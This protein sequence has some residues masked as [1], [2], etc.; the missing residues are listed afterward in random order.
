[1]TL[2]AC[3]F[4]DVGRRATRCEALPDQNSQRAPSGSRSTA[5]VPVG[6]LGSPYLEYGTLKQARGGPQ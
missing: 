3:G 2:L 5:V 6:L 4:L 1:M